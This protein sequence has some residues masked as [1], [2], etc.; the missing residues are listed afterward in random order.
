MSHISEAWKKVSDG[1][2]EVYQAQVNEMM[3]RYKQEYNDW[4]ESLTED[5]KKAE[6]ERTVNKNAKKNHHNNHHNTTVHHSSVAAATAAAVQQATAPM[7][8][9]ASAVP[10]HLNSQ[11]A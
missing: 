1:E 7:M 6:K 8:Q 10:T 2:K 5:E 9:P 11:T 4:Y 3:T